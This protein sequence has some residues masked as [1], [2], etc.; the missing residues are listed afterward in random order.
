M[1]SSSGIKNEVGP[2][3]SMSR[4]MT[5]MP[6]MMDSTAEDN[7]VDSELVPSSLASIA[8][9]LRVAN[10]IEEENPRVA[11]LYA[12]SGMTLGEGAAMPCFS[13][14]A[15]PGQCK[16]IEARGSHNGRD[17]P[18]FGRFHAFEKAHRMD[19]TS[20]GRGVR[21]FKTYL[22]HRL[23][24]LGTVDSP[25]ESVT[26]ASSPD[27]DQQVFLAM[28]ISFGFSIKFIQKSSVGKAISMALWQ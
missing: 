20:S 5:R 17:T 27:N 13:V 2:L 15:G 7:A 21:Q 14:V 9:I 22:L 19:K 11:Y 28:A 26:W 3:R 12:S 1:A 18:A 8:P 24:Q 25:E 23:E 4:R 6:S 10:E 16:R